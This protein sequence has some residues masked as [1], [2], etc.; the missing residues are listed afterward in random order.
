MSAAARAGNRNGILQALR[1]GAQVLHPFN[2]SAAIDRLSENAI[3]H[4]IDPQLVQLNIEHGFAAAVNGKRRKKTK[5]WRELW[6]RTKTGPIPNLANARTALGHAPELFGLFS[7]DEMACAA[8]LNRSMPPRDEAMEPRHVTDSDAN[9]LQDWMQRAGLRRIGKDATRQA[10]D[11]IA[12]ERTFHPVRDYLDGLQWDRTARLGEWLA[13]Y[14]GAEKSPYTAKVGTMFIISMVARIYRPGCKADHIVV[15]EGPQGTLKSTACAVLGGEWFSDNLPDIT[16]GKD[17]SQH[18]RGKWLIEVAEMHAMSKAEASLLKSFISRTT[19]RYRPPYG[20]FEVAE[21]RQC[22]FVGTTNRDT[23]LRDET[24]GRR[25][26]PVKTTIIDIDGLKR[27]RDQ[28][29]A[30]AVE[31]FDAGTPWWPDRDFERDHIAPQQ[32]A[33]YEGDAWEDP[34]GEHLQTVTMTT[35]HQVAR[36]ALGFE[37]ARIGTR[38]QRRI[39]SI[40]TDLGWKRGQREAGTGKRLWIRM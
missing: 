15:V 28:L 8:V 36:Y 5:D 14:L 24:G 2:D 4:G 1:D 37:S 25:F 26:W 33:R 7:Y 23:Y 30:E 29:F 13:T 21:E 3:A 17:V 19:E 32:A 6:Q 22:V 27:D 18:L 16:A 31:L 20:H 12:R 35:I 38:D 9:Q 39:A 40:L 34:I 11:I 10:I